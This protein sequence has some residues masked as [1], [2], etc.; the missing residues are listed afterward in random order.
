MAGYSGR[1]VISC[2]I[3]IRTAT[4]KIQHWLLRDKLVAARRSSR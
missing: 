2:R 3:V 1:A 4:G